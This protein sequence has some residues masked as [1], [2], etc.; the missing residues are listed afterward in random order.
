MAYSHRSLTGTPL[1]VTQRPNWN[2]FL[3]SVNVSLTESVKNVLF[4]VMD[5]FLKG[6]KKQN[7]RNF[8]F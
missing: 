4:E 5:I 1:T 6:P 8:L 7:C 3:G 2:T